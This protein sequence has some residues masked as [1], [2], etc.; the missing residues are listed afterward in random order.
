[1]LQPHVRLP[2][3][4]NN[5]LHEIQR[6]TLIF[7]GERLAKRRAWFFSSMSLTTEGGNRLTLLELNDTCADSKDPG[8]RPPESNC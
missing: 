5:E 3:D 4:S 1:M 7:I 2:A 8:M 6:L